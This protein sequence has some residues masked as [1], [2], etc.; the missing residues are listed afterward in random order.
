M[1]LNNFSKITSFLLIAILLSFPACSTFNSLSDIKKP[2]LSISDAS[3]TNLS[4]KDIELT[5]DVDI[6]NPNPVA[7]NLSDYNYDFKLNENSFVSGSKASETE[8]EASSSSQIQ[9]PVSFSYS[10]LYEMFSNLK[11]QD[12]T[13]YEFLF[14]AGIDAPVLGRF[15]VPLK[16]TGVIPVVKMPR[17]NLENVELENLSFT[18]AEI[19]VNLIIDNPNNFNL[20]FSEL[21]YNLK[22]NNSSPFTGTIEEEFNIG[23]SSE[24]TISV[25][26]SFNLWSLVPPP[27]VF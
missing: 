4:L 20:I 18:K 23:E 19:A 22:L 21:N 1:K 8:I 16:K 17:I 3:I 2:E 25:P 7:V 9:V 27:K 10:E 12:E 15:E 14:N 26:L 11:D 24:S 5:F 13:A 6:K